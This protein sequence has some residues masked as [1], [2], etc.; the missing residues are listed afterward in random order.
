MTVPMV[1]LLLFGLISLLWLA[2]GVAMIALPAWW[3]ERMR[4][5]L[6]DPLRRF[7]LLQGVLLVGLVLV[8]GAPERRGVWLW[9]TLGLVAA[10][11]ALLLLGL[12]DRLRTALTDWWTRIP[13]WT[14]RAAG[15]VLTVL[16][17][18]LAIDSFSGAP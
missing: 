1:T 5:V 12:P 6:S 3:I 10:A 14:H 4:A 2:A 7:V 13:L 11:K 17:T 16:A 15:L 9:A 18:L 8:L